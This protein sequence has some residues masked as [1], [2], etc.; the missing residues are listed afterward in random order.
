MLFA[1]TRGSFGEVI[2]ADGWNEAQR[3]ANERGWQL[4]GEIVASGEIAAGREYLE[5]ATRRLANP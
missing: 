5:A 4:E 2:E 1:A 3:T